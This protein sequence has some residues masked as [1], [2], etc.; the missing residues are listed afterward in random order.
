MGLRET[1]YTGGQPGGEAPIA[2]WSNLGQRLGSTFAA[3]IRGAGLR[4]SARLTHIVEPSVQYQYMP[5]VDQQSL[6]QFDAVDFVS[7]RIG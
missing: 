7:R 4:V 2:S 5:W 6:L 3:A 1:A